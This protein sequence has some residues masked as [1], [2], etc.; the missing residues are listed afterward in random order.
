VCGLGVQ[1]KQQRTRKLEK[2]WVSPAGSTIL[3][4]P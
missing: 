3:A 2:H 1:Q 4:A